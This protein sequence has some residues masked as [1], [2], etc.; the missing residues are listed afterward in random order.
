MIHAI[1]RIFADATPVQPHSMRQLPTLAVLQPFRNDVQQQ[2]L[3]G[4]W[5]LQ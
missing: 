4:D 2:E 1:D 5:Q 3:T